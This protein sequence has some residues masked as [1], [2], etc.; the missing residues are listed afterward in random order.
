[1]DPDHVS[2][3]SLLSTSHPPQRS[4]P[5]PY[6]TLFRSIGSC[7]RRIPGRRSC[8]DTRSSDASQCPQE[9]RFH[10]QRC[11][12]SR[13]RL[14]RTFERSRPDRKSTRLNSSHRTISYAVFCLKKK[15]QPQITIVCIGNSFHHR[16]LIGLVLS[17]NLERSDLVLSHVIDALFMIFVALPLPQIPLLLH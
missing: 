16:L 13:L 11:A 4:T 1:C 14:S 3:L 6:T 17:H 12:A 9:T 8:D 15:K 10:N 2:L 5:F 7:L